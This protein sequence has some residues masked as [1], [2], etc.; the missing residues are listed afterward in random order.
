[1][2]PPSEIS[3]LAEGLTAF[4]AAEKACPF[5]KEP[6]PPSDKPCPN[7]KAMSDEGCRRQVL[8]A[9]GLVRIVKALRTHLE[10]TK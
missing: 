9:F 2:T 4:E 3:R 5:F 6:C 10:S 8:A 1:M 7:C